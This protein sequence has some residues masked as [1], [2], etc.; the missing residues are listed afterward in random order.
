MAPHLLIYVDNKQ[1]FNSLYLVVINHPK[2][3]AMRLEKAAI[4]REGFCL[5]YLD[6]G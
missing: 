4:T 2:G 6:G 1:E 3:E 5:V